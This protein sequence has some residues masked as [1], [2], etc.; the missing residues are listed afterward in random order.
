MAN[1]TYQILKKIESLKMFWVAKKGEKANQ[2]QAELLTGNKHDFMKT[3]GIQC[4]S[5]CDIYIKHAVNFLIWERNEHPEKELKNLKTIPKEHVGEWIQE[6]IDSGDSEY[7][8]RLKGASMAKIMR[9]KSNDFGVKSPS[10]IG[11]RDTITKK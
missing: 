5:T 2:C 6:S 10:K 9:C 8:T 3:Y 4:F 11:N 1:L 7:T